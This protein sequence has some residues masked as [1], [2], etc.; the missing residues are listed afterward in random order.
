MIAEALQWLTEA[1][2]VGEKTIINDG[3][4]VRHHYVVDSNGETVLVTQTRD[5]KQVSEQVGDLHSLIAR[6]NW[7]LEHSHDRFE[8]ENAVAF[9]GP[10]SVVVVLDAAPICPT[11]TNHEVVHDSQRRNIIHLKLVQ[12]KA[13]EALTALCASERWSHA[14]L[15]SALRKHGLYAS[16]LKGIESISVTKLK[17]SHASE[18]GLSKSVRTGSG[19]N[20]EQVPDT[21]TFRLPIYSNDGFNENLDILHGFSFCPDNDGFSVHTR[22]DFAREQQG[23]LRRVAAHFEANTGVQAVLGGL[24]APSLASML[25]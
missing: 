13:M 8:R 2:R 25:D 1:T 12:S 5:H 14:E 6:V 24:P 19:G 7:L 15:C 11:A 21:A 20:E 17:N 22:D 16:E 4:G 9:F 10:Q 18:E 23:L 3:D